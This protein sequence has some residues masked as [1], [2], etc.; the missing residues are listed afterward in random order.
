MKSR[1]RRT[2]FSHRN[3]PKVCN[4][5]YYVVCRFISLSFL[6]EK[7]HHHSQKITSSYYKSEHEQVFHFNFLPMSSKKISLKKAPCQFERNLSHEGWCFP[8][9]SFFLQKY[10]CSATQGNLDIWLVFNSAAFELLRKLLRICNS[11]I[12]KIDGYSRLLNWTHVGIIRNGVDLHPM[13]FL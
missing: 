3:L 12:R 13:V 1:V 7:L 11:R 9:F 6:S 10:Q 5:S 8:E 2:S 4:A